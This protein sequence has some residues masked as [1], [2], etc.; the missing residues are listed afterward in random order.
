MQIHT[1]VI[2]TRVYSV[3]EY[4]TKKPDKTKKKQT[5]IR[6]KQKMPISLQKFAFRAL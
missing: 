3:N 6:M 5:I 4:L 1:D 2:P